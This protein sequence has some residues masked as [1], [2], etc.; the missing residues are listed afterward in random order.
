MILLLLSAIVGN[1]ILDA[2]YAGE[3]WKREIGLVIRPV[4]ILLIREVRVRLK[5]R[6]DP[7]IGFGRGVGRGPV[8]PVLG[9]PG[10]NIVDRS[11]LHEAETLALLTVQAVDLKDHGGRLATL[12]ASPAARRRR[13]AHRLI[14]VA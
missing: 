3:V 12:A 14:V 7:V 10:Q 11:C 8:Q 9:Y 13:R 6:I 2:L 1:Q 4:A 5:R